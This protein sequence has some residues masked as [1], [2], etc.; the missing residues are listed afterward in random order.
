MTSV[1]LRASVLAA[2]LA[3]A[4]PAAAVQ[5][6]LLPDSESQ[7]TVGDAATGLT[8]PGTLTASSGLLRVAL[9]GIAADGSR[10]LAFVA[11]N[12]NSTTPPDDTTTIQTIAYG[13]TAAPANSAT[14]PAG[15][16]V[17]VLLYDAPRTR[18]VGVLQ[19]D[20]HP[21]PGNEQPTQLFT[22]DAAQATGLGEPS[23]LRFAHNAFGKPSLAEAPGCHFN[24]SHSGDAA[25]LAIDAGAPV[26][27]DIEIERAMDD[28]DAMAQAHF[29]DAE[30]DA[31][32]RSS[33]GTRAA[34]FLR[35]WTR[36]EACLKAVGTGLSVDP[37]QLETGCADAPDEARLDDAAHGARRLHL[38]SGRLAPDLLYSVAS[39]RPLRPA[40]G[41]SS[42]AE[43]FA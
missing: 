42:R 4:V 15:R 36:K 8:T 24:L 12:P 35:T 2:S 3:A 16:T 22:V 38:R 31:L 9:G 39:T 29:T 1:L 41:A 26:G 32:Q 20:S 27:V 28:I 5:L 40:R 33:A 6:S 19:D 43:A 11:I 21:T 23:A 17:S 25:L 37:R 34:A 30:R 13:G 14:I 7:V 10:Q 18:L